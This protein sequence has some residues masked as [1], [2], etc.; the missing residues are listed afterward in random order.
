[1]S[2]PFGRQPLKATYIIYQLFSTLFVRLPWWFLLSLPKSWR[3]KLTWTMQRALYVKV[4][5]HVTMVAAKTD[6]LPK[7][8]NHLDILHGPGVNGVWVDATPDLVIGELKSFAD[9]ASVTSVRIPGYWIHKEGSQVEVG[10]PPA[11][12]EKVVY[13]LHGGAYTLLSAHPSS[14]TAMTVKGLL[15]FTVTVRRV[16]ALEYRLSSAEPSPGTNPFPAALLD[17]VAGYHYLV[18]VV[19]FSPSD[20]VILGDSAGGNLAHALTRYLVENSSTPDAKLPAPPGGLILIAPWCDLSD[21]QAIPGSSVFTC[22]ESD[23]IDNGMLRLSAAAFLGP[24]GF[25][26]SE[27][28]RYISPACIYPSLAV[29]FKGFPRTYMVAGGAEVLLSQIR[30]LKT[31]MALDLGEGNGVEMG[32]GKLKYVEEPD[33][34][35]VFHLFKWHEPERSRSLEDIASWMPPPTDW[36]CAAEGMAN[37]ILDF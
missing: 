17:A 2:L 9:A 24:H 32:E 7:Y 33:A 15:E 25:E 20:I 10:S 16:F 31:R 23:F 27:S 8:P 30:T 22:S 29:D 26:A 18:N 4:I 34:V 35:H 13:H 11:F 36:T 19:G 12:G 5:R 6:I 37:L 14:S 21:S 3:P 28:N 1:M